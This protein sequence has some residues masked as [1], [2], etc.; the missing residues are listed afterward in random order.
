MHAISSYH[1]NRPTNKQTNTFTNTHT[2]THRQDRLQYTAPQCNKLTLTHCNADAKIPNFRPSNAAPYKMPPWV[3]ALP[4]PASRRHWQ[5]GIIPAVLLESA[6]VAKYIDTVLFYFSAL[7][8]CLCVCMD[9]CARG[10][11]QISTNVGSAPVSRVTR[12]PSVPTHWAVTTANVC[13]DMRV[14][15]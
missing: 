10:T 15:P 13:P 5:F 12:T 9:A 2:Q 7:C 4:P 6:G 1:G 11:N 8:V 14:M 3:A